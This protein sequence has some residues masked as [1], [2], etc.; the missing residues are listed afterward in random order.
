MDHK[1]ERRNPVIEISQ[2]VAKRL[3]QSALPDKRLAFFD[4][5]EG[6]YS[7]TNYRVT[8]SDESAVLLRIF[9]NSVE[10]AKKEIQLL[11]KMRGIP[12]PGV[13]HFDSSLA[14]A[15]FAYALLEW[16]NGQ[17]LNRAL[18]TLSSSNQSHV[19]AS[20]GRILSQLT[21]I[22]FQKMGF[23]GPGLEIHEAFGDLWEFFFPFIEECLVRG[24]AGGRLGQDLTKKVLE[25]A[26]NH[27]G[28]IT[29]LPV[30]PSLVHGDFNGKNIL[31]EKI[32]GNWEVTILD[33]EFAYCGP[34][35]TDFGNLF[36]YDAQLST[37]FEVGIIKG[38]QESGNLLPRQWKKAAKLLDLMNLCDFL[39]T[40]KQ[41][42]ILWDHSKGLIQDTI[43]RWDTF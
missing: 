22:R 28:L 9:S 27:K 14:H 12:V 41:K 34:F 6:G 24:P 38:F 8:L 21:G 30:N 13:I 16:K 33:W 40:Q 1:G 2:E 4:L 37:S 7:N 23:L 35:L 3:I 19:G 11:T 18:P 31:V 29:D 36:R 32:Q 39:N 10:T 15:P 43:Q 5:L 26:Q 17:P 42:P 20:L 25:L